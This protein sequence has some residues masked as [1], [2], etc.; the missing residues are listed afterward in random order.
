[1]DG[2]SRLLWRQAL[3]EEG[4]L[5]SWRIKFDDQT[6]LRRLHYN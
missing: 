1:M 5:D 3:T 2:Q 6:E 4:K